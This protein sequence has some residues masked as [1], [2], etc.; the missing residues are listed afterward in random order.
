MGGGVGAL[1]CQVGPS[2][3]DPDI[4]A[5][6]EKHKERLVQSAPAPFLGCSLGDMDA[7]GRALT[8]VVVSV[9]LLVLLI[10]GSS[11]AS[12]LGPT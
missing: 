1:G 8:L 2:N 9:W 12:A 4:G 10:Q 6:Y 11:W 3:A 5:T 7:P